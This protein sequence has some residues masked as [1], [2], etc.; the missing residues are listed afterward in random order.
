MRE[1]DILEARKRYE[2]QWFKI[3]GFVGCYNTD[4]EIVVEIDEFVFQ[5]VKDRFPNEVEGIPVI[6]NHLVE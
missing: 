4:E 5:K 1:K 2:P 3:P 6:K